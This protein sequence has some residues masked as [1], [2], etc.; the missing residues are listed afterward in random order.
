M[1]A[2]T[3]GRLG[4]LFGCGEMMRGVCVELPLH[5][6]PIKLVKLEFRSFDFMRRMFLVEKLCYVLDRFFIRFCC[7]YF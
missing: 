1:L 2:G 4:C 5:H 6:V 3:H 7:F